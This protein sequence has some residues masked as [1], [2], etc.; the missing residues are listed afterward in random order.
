LQKKTGGVCWGKTAV[1]KYGSECSRATAHGWKS[2]ELEG[3][4]GK[5]VPEIAA[6]EK[7]G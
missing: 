6:G 1:L 2:R 7:I 5:C 3:C 4:Q